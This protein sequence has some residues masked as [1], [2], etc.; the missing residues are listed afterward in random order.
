[1][2]ERMQTYR[3]NAYLNSRRP[4]QNV[5]VEMVTDEVV[6]IIITAP[7]TSKDVD[8]LA[9][10]LAHLVDVVALFAEDQTGNPFQS[11]T[12]VFEAARVQIRARKT[13]DRKESAELPA[14]PPF[15]GASVDA[16]ID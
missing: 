7:L 8:G 9:W 2:S 11:F 13:R 1:M 10:Q 6:Q 3:T 15:L 5:D 12:I 16:H 4:F 14:L